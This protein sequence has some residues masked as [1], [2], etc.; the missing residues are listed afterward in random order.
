[1]GDIAIFRKCLSATS[2]HRVMIL[3]CTPSLRR[4]VR[5]LS[6]VEQI[7]IVDF[8]PEMWAASSKILPEAGSEHFLLGD[9]CELPAD[10]GFFDAIVGDKILDNIHPMEWTR[11][12]EG[13]SAHLTDEG[14]LILH[15][16][17]RPEGNSTLSFDP[18]E[19][20]TRWVTQIRANSCT[21]EE[22]AAGYW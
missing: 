17:L 19:A 4:L 15:V 3:G 8:T 22:A 18:L 5:G 6:T 16:G 9:W 14:S 11:F 13:A 1:D 2:P 7:I 20:F 21:L 12:L 10:L